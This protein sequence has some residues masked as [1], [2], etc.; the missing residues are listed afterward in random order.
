M[1][2]R[3]VAG[4]RAKYAGSMFE[5][6]FENMCAIQNIE[7][8]RIPDSCRQ[9]GA[10]KLIRVYS[11]FDFVLCYR[12]RAA[13]VDLKSIDIGNLTYSKIVPHQLR[14]LLKLS[15]GGVSGYI[16]NVAGEVYFVDV[17]ILQ[18]TKPGKSVDLTYA[19]NLGHRASFDIRRIF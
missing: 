13:F 5:T 18:S 7:C 17:S 12:Q 8:V 11:P 10:N 19:K 9:V 2:S 14:N 15:P 6:L 1:L 4:K 3:R 16:V